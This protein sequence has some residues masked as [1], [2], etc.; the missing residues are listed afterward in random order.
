[1]TAAA[2]T[3]DVASPADLA[4][5]DALLSRSYPVL[6]KPDYPPS[7]LVTAL[8]LISRAQPRLLAC[9]T[10]YV[11]RDGDEIVGAGGWTMAAPGG[12]RA[13]QR[14]GH[15]RHVVTD[16]RRTRQGIGRALMARVFETARAAGMTRLEA[17]ATRT[18]VSFY[19]AMGFA[20]LGAVDVPL[21]PGIV[22]PAVAMARAP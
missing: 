7:V 19:R 17:Q 6:L 5:V 3:V 1:M 16:H 4:A 18:A 15:I 20:V 2:I 22:F 14:V 10:Y 21:R 13:R 9:G 8:P 11:A 12:A